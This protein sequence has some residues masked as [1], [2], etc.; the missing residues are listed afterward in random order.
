MTTLERNAFVTACLAAAEVARNASG[1][2]DSLG[3][4]IELRDTEL[5]VVRWRRRYP[6]HVGVCPP[7]IARGNSD[8][9]A[10]AL[11]THQQVLDL[12]HCARMHGRQRE[13]IISFTAGVWNYLQ[14]YL[15]DLGA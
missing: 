7:D 13:V 1:T 6:T 4:D 5:L 11:Y 14:D 15:H 2:V 8:E 12:R 10:M 3:V 9:R